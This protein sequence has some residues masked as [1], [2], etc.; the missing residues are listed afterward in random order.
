M[1]NYQI[2]VENFYTDL[3]NE[4]KN[5]SVLICH[6]VTM[7]I[8]GKLSKEYYNEVSKSTGVLNKSRSFYLKEMRYD[9]IVHV[10]GD[11]VRALLEIQIIK[12]LSIYIC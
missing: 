9:A 6:R 10:V 3:A 11:E 12:V 7:D 2:F 5:P 4:L 1:I 8:V